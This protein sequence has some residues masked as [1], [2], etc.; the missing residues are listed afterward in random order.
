MFF[1]HVAQLAG[2]VQYTNR[3]SGEGQDHPKE[4]PVYDTKKTDS[5]VPIMQ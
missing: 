1:P 2:V 5:E 4:C 3:I